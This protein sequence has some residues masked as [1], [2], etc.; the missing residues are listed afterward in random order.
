M[1]KGSSKK[2]ARR[3]QKRLGSFFTITNCLV[4]VIA[5]TSLVII[6][7]SMH[8][9]K[10]IYTTDLLSVIAEGESKGNYNA[11]FN[12]ASN[13]QIQFTAMPVAD[14][15]TWQNEFINNGNA[16]S[17]VGRYQFINT[18]LSGLIKENNIDPSTLFDE[19]L[20][21]ALA[22]ALLERRG[23]QDFVNKKI[24]REQF[25]HNLSMEWAALPKII[26][27][28]PSSSFY[29]NDGLNK[30]HVSIAEIYK[31]IDSVQEIQQ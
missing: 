8:Q 12:N 27:K 7:Q 3:I 25:A 21:D 6:V 2:I 4:A 9:K 18:T 28:D 24:T 26:G 15:L 31:G 14:V 22:V 1:S 19:S 5:I 23:L 30:A 17:A 10:E 13:T 29:A 11:Y 20:Q 16:S